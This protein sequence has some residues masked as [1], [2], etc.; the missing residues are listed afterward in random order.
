MLTNNICA[1]VDTSLAGEMEQW[2]LQDTAA[3]T[4]K[5]I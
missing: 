5:M 1:Y 3:N 4:V 2:S